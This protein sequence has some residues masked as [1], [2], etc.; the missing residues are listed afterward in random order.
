MEGRGQSTVVYR[1]SRLPSGQL[2]QKFTSVATLPTRTTR[3]NM[4]GNHTT[5]PNRRTAD[6]VRAVS[7]KVQ[8]STRYVAD[9]MAF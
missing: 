5:F 9:T 1:V 6:A 7:H 2:A 3:V 8:V 4:N